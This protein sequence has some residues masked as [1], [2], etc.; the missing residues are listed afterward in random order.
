MTIGILKIHISIP[1]CRS[2]KEKRSR[3]KPLLFR[4]H[5]L[6]N[7]SA[8]EIGLNDKWQESIIAIALIGNGKEYINHCLDK[9]IDSI[10]TNFPDLELIDKQIEIF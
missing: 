4:I 8:A 1:L 6:Y 9:I 10:E 5:K 3:V 2:L 7:V